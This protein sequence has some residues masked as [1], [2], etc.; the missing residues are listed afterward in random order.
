MAVKCPLCGGKT[1]NNECTSCGYRLPDESD[2][3]SLYNYDPSDYPQENPSMPETGYTYAEPE[4]VNVPEFKVR[5]NPY[6][7]NNAGAS[8]YADNN[9][10]SPYENNNGNPYANNNG[11]FTPY[12]SPQNNGGNQKQTYQ[13][14]YA[15]FN[16]YT[17]SSSPSE[18]FGE[19]F[20]QFWWL[21][22]VSFF[23]PIVGIILYATMNHKINAKFHTLIKIIIVLGFVL[24]P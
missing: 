3:S 18:D 17:S 15:N 6:A 20:R 5:E 14:P 13:N 22:L 23:L 21:L 2:L 1:V 19:F 9:G 8:P 24:P 7:E 16:P 11:N 10:A 4:N 12:Q